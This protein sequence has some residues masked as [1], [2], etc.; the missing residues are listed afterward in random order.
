MYVCVCVCIY[1][2]IY[3]YKEKLEINPMKMYRDEKIQGIQRMILFV[4]ILASVK[5]L[6]LCIMYIYIY[7]YIYH[8]H[9]HIYK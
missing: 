9:T 8:T 7:I 3:I 5:C 2:Y 6:L 4:E 1:I